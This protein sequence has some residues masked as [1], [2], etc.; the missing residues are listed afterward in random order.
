MNGRTVVSLLAML[1]ISIVSIA[2]MRTLG[3]PLDLSDKRTASMRIEDTNGLVVGS[4]VLLRGSDIGTVTA[5]NPNADGIVVE[6]EYNDDVQIPVKTDFRVDNLSALGETYIAVSPETESGPFLGD[7]EYIDATRIVVPATIKELSQ[8]FTTLLNQ[9][10]EKKIQSI[11]AELDRG[12]PAGTR[13]ITT[14]EKAGIITA[15]MMED[16]SGSLNQ[17]LINAQKMLLDSD[18]IAPGLAGTARYI[19]PFS[20][21]FDDVMGASVSFTNLAPLPEGLTLGTGPLLDNVQAFLDRSATDIKVLAVDLLPAAEASSQ[22]LSTINLGTLLDR[23]L[24][25]TS[26]GG[27]LSVEVSSRGK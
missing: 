11:F 10:D 9:L 15:A 26:V 23:A 24:A 22:A 5:V 21:G 18:F 13:T 12:L 6:L 14:I 8:R 7:A 20:Q 17:V 19:V 16:T 27:A 1:T 25:A 3:L 2:Y 4:R